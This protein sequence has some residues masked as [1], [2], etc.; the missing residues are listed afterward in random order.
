[1]GFFALLLPPAPP[2]PNSGANQSRRCKQ[3]FSSY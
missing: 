2:L 3:Y 1:M